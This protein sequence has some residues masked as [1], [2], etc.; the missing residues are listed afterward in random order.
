[1]YL[2]LTVSVYLCVHCTYVQAPG[3]NFKENNPF[4]ELPNRILHPWPAMQEFQFHVRYGL[5]TH[6]C[7]HTYMYT[8]IYIRIYHPP[9]SCSDDLMFL[10]GRL[11]DCWTL[12]WTRTIE[13]EHTTISTFSWREQLLHWGNRIK[14]EVC[15]WYE[16]KSEGVDLKRILYSFELSC[17]IC[18][19]VP[20]PTSQ[21][22]SALINKIEAA[23]SSSP[24]VKFK[25]LKLKLKLDSM[26]D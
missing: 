25:R 4:E 6:M 2:S 3:E 9:S 23:S 14:K 17:G 8:H 13:Y 10:R 15:L 5:H 11:Y 12:L 21:P 18:V 7:T 19:L 16:L 20:T 1:M 26:I 24:S 22:C